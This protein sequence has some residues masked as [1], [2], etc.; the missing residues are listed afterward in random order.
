MTSEIH[1]FCEDLHKLELCK[2]LRCYVTDMKLRPFTQPLG[3]ASVENPQ[4]L[5]SEPILAIEP[6]RDCSKSTS[7]WPPPGI[8]EAVARKI[9][10]PNETSQPKHIPRHDH[11]CQAV[12]TYIPKPVKDNCKAPSWPPPVSPSTIQQHSSSVKLD[13]DSILPERFSRDTTMSSI[14]I[15]LG[16]MVLPAPLK[17]S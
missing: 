2:Y 7:D 9:R 5:E 8:I 10:I 12:P 4:R 6:R 13:P 1:K 15:S 3:G 17:Q 14:K 11:L 16:I